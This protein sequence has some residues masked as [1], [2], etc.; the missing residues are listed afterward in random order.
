MTPAL[1]LLLFQIFQTLS[2][3]H[4]LDVEELCEAALRISRSA[5]PGGPEL[6]SRKYPAHVKTAW[7]D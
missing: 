5:A 1:N 4:G 7:T 2:E 3:G 6:A